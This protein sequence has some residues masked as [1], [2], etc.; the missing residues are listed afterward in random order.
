MRSIKIRFVTRPENTVRRRVGCT[1]QPENFTGRG[2][3]G[4]NCFFSSWLSCLGA[5]LSHFH[6]LR[7]LFILNPLQ[8]CIWLFWSHYEPNS[9][10]NTSSTF[11]SW[12]WCTKSD[13]DVVVGWCNTSSRAPITT[14]NTTT[15]TGVVVAYTEA[16]EGVVTPTSATIKTSPSNW[17]Q[18]NERQPWLSRNSKHTA[19]TKQRRVWKKDEEEEKKERRRRKRKKEREEE[20]K[21]ERK[22]WRKKKKKEEE[23]KEERKQRNIRARGGGVTSLFKD[24]TEKT[25]LARDGTKA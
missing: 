21:E 7:F 4:V 19:E 17:R 15:A 23:A 3:E 5:C 9:D 13:P 20:E 8:I 16:S 11:Q 25:V 24:P 18:G 22:R 14:P 12:T 1:F 10:T 6:S 2:S